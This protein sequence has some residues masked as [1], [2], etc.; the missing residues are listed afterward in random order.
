MSG[1]ALVRSFRARP[2]H[3]P[4]TSYHFEPSG[5]PAPPKSSEAAIEAGLLIPVGD[6]LF[7]ELSQSFRPSR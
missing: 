5:R 1:G 7:P 3:P 6:G 2:N 4:E